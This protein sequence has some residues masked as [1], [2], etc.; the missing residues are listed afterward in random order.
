MYDRVIHATFYGITILF[1]A[2]SI[3]KTC[4][5]VSNLVI[6]SSEIYDHNERPNYKSIEGNEYIIL[7][8]VFFNNF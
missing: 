7:I 8:N 4:V 1:Y 5:K 3:G 6:L 2:E